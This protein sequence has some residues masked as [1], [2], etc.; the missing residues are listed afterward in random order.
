VQLG[1]RTVLVLTGGTKREDLDRFAYRPDLVVS[2]L[3]QFSEILSDAD[4]QS[5]W[6]GHQPATRRRSPAHATA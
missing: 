3:A 2:S 5:P 6:R 4:W 1:F